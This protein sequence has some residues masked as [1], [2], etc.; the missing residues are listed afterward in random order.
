[1]VDSG[2]DG[3]TPASHTRTP[4]SESS[5]GGDFLVIRD[6]VAK[7]EQPEGQFHQWQFRNIPQ[8]VQKKGKLEDTDE[9]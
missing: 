4:A 3:L 8:D 2:G 1:M 7:Y 5:N 9:G 6:L